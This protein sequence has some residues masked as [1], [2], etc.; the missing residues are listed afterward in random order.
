MCA[1]RH[2]SRVLDKRRVRR[3]GRNRPARR[4]G[5]G[6]ACRLVGHRARGTERSRR[7][8][9]SGASVCTN[10]CP[11]PAAGPDRDR[12]PVGQLRVVVRELGDTNRCGCQPSGERG[13]AAAV[14]IADYLD[15]YA[16]DDATAV[17]LT[18]LEGVS[19]GSALYESLTGATS[20]K[21]VVLVKGGT[22]AGGQRAAASH[23][24]SLASDERVFA[25]LCRQAG[26]TARPRSRRHSRRR[27]PSRR[28]RCREDREP[29][30]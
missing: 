11:Q 9:D 29:R 16:H 28:S 15:W 25:S 1:T 22:T 8:V 26:V 19:D 7:R 14:G 12:E 23:T 17:C 21:P 5:S 13:N 4:G 18:Y 30:S 6:R 24:G 10:R 27:R 20:K 2:P 3:G